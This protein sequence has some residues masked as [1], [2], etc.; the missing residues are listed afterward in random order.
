[1][2]NTKQNSEKDI[3]YMLNTSTHWNG[4]Y[5]YIRNTYN[6]SEVKVLLVADILSEYDSSYHPQASI[7]QITNSEDDSTSYCVQWK[8]QSG[9]IRS[10]RFDYFIDAYRWFCVVSDLDSI[11]RN[12]ALDKQKY[13]FFYQSNKDDELEQCKQN[14]DAM[15]EK[16]SIM[17]AKKE[18]IENRIRELLAEK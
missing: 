2:K 7:L 9:Y 15:N 1:M 6:R 14:L 16:I 12:S 8:N 13:G 18:R 5:D 11:S 10:D 4:W 17:I 3:E